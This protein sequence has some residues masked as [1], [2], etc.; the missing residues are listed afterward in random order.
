MIG[1][2]IG[3]LIDKEK[4]IREYIENTIEDVAEELGVPPEE[5][6]IMIKPTAKN[7]NSFQVHLYQLKP[8]SAPVHVRQMALKEF[9][10]D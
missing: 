7:D 9:V 8:G 1:S 10:D 6:F 3:G 5:V 4:I 2:L